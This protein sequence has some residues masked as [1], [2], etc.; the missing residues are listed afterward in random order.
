[1]KSN[2]KQLFCLMFFLLIFL[3]FSSCSKDNN[4]TNVKPKEV[5]PITF[6]DIE[7]YVSLH[8]DTNSDIVI[9]NIQGGP[10]LYLEEKGLDSYIKGSDTENVLY[11]NVHQTQT[12]TPFLFA[13][14]I[15]LEDAE[16]Y[17]Q[18]SVDILK[19]VMDY[20]LFETN[21][22]VYFLGIS[23]GAF[24][25]QELI[26]QYRTPYVSGCLVIGARLKID[27]KALEILSNGLI[28][29][30]SFDSKG[31]FSID[32]LVEES[33][34]SDVVL[35]N[36]AMLGYVVA[37]HDYTESLAFIE[38][39]SK[40]TFIYGERDNFIG[41]LSKKE[42]DFLNKRKANVICALM[43]NHRFTIHKSLLSIKDVFKIE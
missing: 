21:K 9:I 23:Y 41:P 14:K 34:E 15:S 42:L 30:Y 17:T 16:K 37:K 18:K 10:I 19:K 36:M 6:K 24:L 3:S 25:L 35:Y 11:V 26:R 38:T 4:E 2:L 43:G 40:T 12:L 22:S 20:Y 7:P 31:K 13:K 27:N 39:L 32:V 33:K 28:P 8:G 29:K 5:L 1:M